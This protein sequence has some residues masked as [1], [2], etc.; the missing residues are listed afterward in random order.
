MLNEDEWRQIQPHLGD[1]IGQIKEAMRT[2][3]LS[4]VDARQH[5]WGKSALERYYELT[6]HQEAVPD[7]LFHHR[8]SLL[9]PPCL[10]CGKPLRT[11]KA[12]F[13]AEC[14]TAKDT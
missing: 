14:G 6:G 4:L 1:V 5:G 3:S 2:E 10:A 9:G 11:P 7:N 12:K 13:C 8:L